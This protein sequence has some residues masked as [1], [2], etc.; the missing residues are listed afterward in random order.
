MWLK[1]RIRLAIKSRRIETAYSDADSVLLN[2]NLTKRWLDH[3]GTSN[4]PRHKQTFVAEP[5]DVTASTVASVDQFA[6]ILGLDWCLR[7]NSYWF[8]G[9]TFRIEFWPREES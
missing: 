9:N 8:P 6:E 7:A 1:K 3:W 2:C 4:T 5:Y